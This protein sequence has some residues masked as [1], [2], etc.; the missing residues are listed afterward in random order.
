[1]TKKEPETGLAFFQLHFKKN[2]LDEGTLLFECKTLF[3]LPIF[4]S[5]KKSKAL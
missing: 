5:M 1:M 2:A 4:M 3:F